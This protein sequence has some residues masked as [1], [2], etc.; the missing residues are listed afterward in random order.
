MS[1]SNRL[2][3][4]T[5]GFTG[6][7]AIIGAGF[8]AWVFVGEDT[9]VSSKIDAGVSVTQHLEVGRLQL[10]SEVEARQQLWGNNPNFNKYDYTVTNDPKYEEFKKLVNEYSYRKIVFSEGNPDSTALNDG[11]QFL[12]FYYDKSMDIKTFKEEPYIDGEFFIPASYAQKGIKFHIGV[13]TTNIDVQTTEVNQ[14]STIDDFVQLNDKYEP[15]IDEKDPDKINYFKVGNNYYSSFNSPSNSGL[16]EWKLSGQKEI[17]KEDGTKELCDVYSFKSSLDEMFL[18]EPGMK[19]YNRDSVQKIY[20]AITA[21][22]KDGT[23]ATKWRIQFEFAS[24][25]YQE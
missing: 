17:I 24:C 5:L 20:D 21:A 2:A 11:M 25:L 18:Y 14:A 4:L 22:K 12:R 8:S 6:T 1:R 13:R 23:I 3:F 15:N 16:Y 10:V 9:T 7:L 19:P